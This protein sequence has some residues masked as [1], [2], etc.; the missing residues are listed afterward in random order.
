LFDK[1][2]TTIG[3]KMHICSDELLWKPFLLMRIRL[4]FV[5]YIMAGAKLFYLSDFLFSLQYALK[6]SVN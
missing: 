4:L 3:N 1:P 2:E 5:A 6:G